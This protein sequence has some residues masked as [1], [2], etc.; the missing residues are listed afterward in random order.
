MPIQIGQFYG[1]L[2]LPDLAERVHKNFNGRGDFTR[3]GKM[4]YSI[5]RQ[6][7]KKNLLLHVLDKTKN[8]GIS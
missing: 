3:T 5:P 1:F 2:Q 7:A 6:T 8:K 4:M